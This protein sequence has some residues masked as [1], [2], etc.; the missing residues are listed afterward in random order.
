MG[1]RFLVSEVRIKMGLKELKR[2]GEKFYVRYIA[3]K[4]YRTIGN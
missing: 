1:F 4:S 2:G 3:E